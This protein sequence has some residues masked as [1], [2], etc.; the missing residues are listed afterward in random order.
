[1]RF[2]KIKWLTVFLGI[3]ITMSWIV[4]PTMAGDATEEHPKSLSEW[5]RLLPEETRAKVEIVFE[6]NLDCMGNSSENAQPD[7]EGWKAS[8]YKNLQQVLSPE[9]LKGFIRIMNI[10]TGDTG[11]IVEQLSTVKSGCDYC[12][13][14]YMSLGSAANQ[15]ESAL[16]YNIPSYCDFGFYP[17]NITPLIIAALSRTNMAATKAY[18]AYLYCNCSYAQDALYQAQ[19]AKWKLDAAISLS[20]DP[21]YNCSSNPW[22]FPLLMARDALDLAIPQLNV[23][24]NQTC[25]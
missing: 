4:T 5:M 1:M 14:A 21:R 3:L 9:E 24:V 15:L 11:N 18:K 12:N 16:N 13:Y 2:S 8:I 6:C 19:Q 23:C 25:N 22:L 10:D 17:D 20:K 7:V